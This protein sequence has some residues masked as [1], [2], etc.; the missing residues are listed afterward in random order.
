LSHN[1]KKITE[2]LRDIAEKIKPLNNQM[3]EVMIEA[4]NKIEALEEDVNLYKTMNE[5]H[6]WHIYQ[7]QKEFTQLK[8]HCAI[9]EQHMCGLCKSYFED[10]ADVPSCEGCNLVKGRE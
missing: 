2:N 1:D 10:K 5:A 7:R 6:L 9:I 4:A 8:S 3:F